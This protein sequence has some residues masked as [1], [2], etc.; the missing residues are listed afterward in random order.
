LLMTH[1]PPAT[2]HRP[3]TSRVDF[4]GG[5]RHLAPNRGRRATPAI[6]PNHRGTAAVRPAPARGLACPPLLTTHHPP[7]ARGRSRRGGQNWS[8]LTTGPSMLTMR[9]Y[10][11]R[12]ATVFLMNRTL[13]SPSPT[14]TPPG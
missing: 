13:P 14:F 6:L 2:G 9:L 11:T 7:P 8:A 4:S 12:L 3:P 1:Q 10:Q 5:S